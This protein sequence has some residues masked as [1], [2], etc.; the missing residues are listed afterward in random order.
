MAKEL[1]EG[2]V[3]DEIFTS[4][5]LFVGVEAKLDRQ[6]RSL[7]PPSSIQNALASPRGS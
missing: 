6:L 3:R 1:P 4:L 2:Q 7:E 5:S